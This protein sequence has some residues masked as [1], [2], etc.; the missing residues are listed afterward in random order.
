LRD[1]VAAEADSAHSMRRY[2]IA[3]EG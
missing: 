3:T 1:R 2:Q